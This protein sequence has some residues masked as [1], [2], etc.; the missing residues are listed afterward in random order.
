MMI[1]DFE[2]LRKEFPKL[3]RSRKLHPVTEQRLSELLK[4]I[5]PEAYPKSEPGE[6]PGGRSDLGF[7]FGDG[8]YATFEIFAT[9]SQVP[10]DLR[11][12]EPMP[13]S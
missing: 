4:D 6:I 1:Q 11:H 12:L 2:E 13:F 5:Y 7:Y 8:H 3:K 9:K 10:Q